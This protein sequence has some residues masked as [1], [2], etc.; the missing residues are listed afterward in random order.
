MNQPL[1]GVIG[2]SEKTGGFFKWTEDWETLETKK[3]SSL[4]GGKC[5]YKRG[6]KVRQGLIAGEE[7]ERQGD[8][9]G[10]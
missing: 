5:V 7:A 9:K 6:K 8:N 2:K 1:F 10:G 4:A 3:K